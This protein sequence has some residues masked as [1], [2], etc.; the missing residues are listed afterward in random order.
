MAL[1][2][3]QCRILGPEKFLAAYAHG[4]ERFGYRDSPLEVIAYGLQNQFKTGC[5]PFDVG[6]EVEARLTDS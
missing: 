2:V 1:H 5:D 6:A 4:L 3:V